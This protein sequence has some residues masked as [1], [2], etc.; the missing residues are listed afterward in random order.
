MYTLSII[1]KIWI[2][3]NNKFLHFFT[4]CNQKLKFR[5]LTKLRIWTKILIF[6]TNKQIDW[7]NFNCN[8]LNNNK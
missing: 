3:I 5:I 6:L 2:I 7:F 8:K 4:D 1:Y